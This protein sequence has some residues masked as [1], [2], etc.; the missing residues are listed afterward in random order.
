M[1]RGFLRLRHEHRSAHGPVPLP[2]QR[3][4][5]RH[6]LAVGLAGNRRRLLAADARCHRHVVLAIQPCLV[7]EHHPRLLR[8][9]LLLQG[10]SRCLGGEDLRRGRLGRDRIVVRVPR[11]R[12]LRLLHYNPRARWPLR[13]ARPHLLVPACGAPNPS[14]SAPRQSARAPQKFAPGARGAQ[15]GGC[16]QRQVLSGPGL[17]G[18]KSRS[19]PRRAV[20]RLPEAVLARR[21]VRGRAPPSLISVPHRAITG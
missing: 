10:P 1:G 13:I 5:K 7:G 21:W 15:G 11:F 2:E 17:R 12:P 19:G 3:A 14:L 4:R 8:L 9:P 18:C 6:R 20:V 16:H